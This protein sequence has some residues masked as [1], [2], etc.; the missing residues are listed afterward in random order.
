V[1]EPDPPAGTT[2]RVIGVLTDRDIVIGVV[3]QD[4]N[5]KHVLVRDVM[6]RDP[7]TI[8]AFATLPA[9]VQEMRRVGVRRMPVVG[10]QGELF[11]VLSLDDALDVLAGELASLAGAIRNER[12]IESASRGASHPI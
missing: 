10:K 3:A 2:Q 6:T 11:G 4:A 12:R 7:V 5:P 9:A 1:V 8:E